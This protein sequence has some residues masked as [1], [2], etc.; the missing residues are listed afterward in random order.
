[1]YNNPILDVSMVNS[2]YELDVERFK[3]LERRL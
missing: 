3:I 1:M 2:S